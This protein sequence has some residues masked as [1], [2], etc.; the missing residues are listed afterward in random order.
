MDRIILEALI[1][2]SI[3]LSSSY[4]WLKMICL[5]LMGSLLIVLWQKEKP[6][7]PKK[8]YKTERVFI[9]YTCYV[10]KTQDHEKTAIMSGSFEIPPT[11]FSFPFDKEDY[12]NLCEKTLRECAES[13]FSFDYKAK[14]NKEIINGT[15][16]PTGF[17][18][19]RKA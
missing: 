10:D 9:E 3:F 14:A 18:P 6:K 12:K 2:F 13:L 16:K 4:L 17:K 1:I 15:F 8:Q 11:S 5:V 7:K 19:G